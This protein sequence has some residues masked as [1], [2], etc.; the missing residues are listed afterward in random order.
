MEGGCSNSI[1]LMLRWSGAEYI[2]PQDIIFD[3]LYDIVEEIRKASEEKDYY[4][5]KAIQFRNYILSNY[6]IDNFIIEVKNYLTRVRI[7]G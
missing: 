5:R 7:G 2:Y 4:N 6:T 1:G 3:S